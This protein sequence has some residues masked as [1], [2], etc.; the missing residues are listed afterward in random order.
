MT[1]KLNLN[2]LTKTKQTQNQS[3]SKEQKIPPKKHNPKNPHHLL[4]IHRKSHRI[5]V[6]KCGWLYKSTVSNAEKFLL[7]FHLLKLSK[8]GFY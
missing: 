4:A 3:V 8:Q 2:S 7:L 1:Q 5:R 6:N